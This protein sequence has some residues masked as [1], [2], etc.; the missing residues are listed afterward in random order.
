MN[1][2][3]LISGFFILFALVAF[4]RKL[5]LILLVLNIFIALFAVWL[6]LAAA[7]PYF[8]IIR[9]NWIW[10]Y[11]DFVFRSILIFAL[12]LLGINLDLEV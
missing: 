6:I 1:M 8:P 12:K 10:P 2:A 9:N 3:L 5:S 7:A 11:Y 4:K